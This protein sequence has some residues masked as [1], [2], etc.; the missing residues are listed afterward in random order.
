MGEGAGD[1]HLFM[2]KP[3]L[4]SQPVQLRRFKADT[5]KARVDLDLSLR[6]FPDPGSCC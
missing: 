1:L 5:V 3:Q 4:F 6:F 2:A